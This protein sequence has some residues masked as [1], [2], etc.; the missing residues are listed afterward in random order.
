MRVLIV[1]DE[2]L[3]RRSLSRAFTSK[4][5]HVVCADQGL[6][7]LDLWRNDPP[8]AV[9]LDVLM[10]GLTGPQ[11]LKSI[12]VEIRKK[13]VVILVSA[14]AGAENDFPTEVDLFLPKPF[15]DVFFVVQETERLMAERLK[16]C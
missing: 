11:V 15:E 12:E 1:D 3:V 16:N 8:D 13:S 14:Y 5:H 10:P 9:I 6:L 4:G 7:G 2:P